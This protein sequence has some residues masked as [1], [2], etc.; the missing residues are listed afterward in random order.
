MESEASPEP[1]VEQTEL[2]TEVVSVLTELPEPQPEPEPVA[3]EPE[4][5]T[6]AIA[7]AFRKLF[8]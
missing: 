4:E 6:T 5:P 1:P 8:K 7:H 2:L 3:V